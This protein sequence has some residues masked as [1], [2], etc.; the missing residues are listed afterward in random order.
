IATRGA[1]AVSSCLRRIDI[2][3]IDESSRQTCVAEEGRAAVQRLSPAAGAVVQ[4]VWFDAGAQAPGL[5][6]LVIHHLAIDGVSWRI[7][8]PDLAAACEAIASGGPA[9]L[10]LRSTSLRNWAERLTAEAQATKRIAERGV[11]TAMLKRPAL[12]LVDGALDPTR[13]TFAGARHLTLT[14]PRHA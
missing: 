11:W 7:L 8:A 9:Q 4:A 5:L 3:E 14:L 1:V 10:A 13:D 6:L 2:A 12:A